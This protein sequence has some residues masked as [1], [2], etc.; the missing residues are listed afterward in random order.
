[1]WIL[2]KVWTF[3]FLWPCDHK[4]LHRYQRSYQQQTRLFS[5]CRITL[6]SIQFQLTQST[7]NSSSVKRICI[8]QICCDLNVWECMCA[9]VCENEWMRA[10]AFNH[11]LII[12]LWNRIGEHVHFRYNWLSIKTSQILVE[13]GLPMDSQHST[14]YIE[15]TFSFLIFSF[16]FSFVSINQPKQTF[17][18]EINFRFYNSAYTHKLFTNCLKLKTVHR[19]ENL[20]FWEQNNHCRRR[21]RLNQN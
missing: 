11:T 4:Y 7:I 6:L 13:C 12:E 16:V 21:K 15:S 3:I 5:C 20:Q 18:I 9:L 14:C 10:R 2:C 17:N 8:E 1:M 19:L